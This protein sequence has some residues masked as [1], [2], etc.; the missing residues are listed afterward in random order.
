MAKRTQRQPAARRRAPGPGRGVRA[1]MA[2]GAS[3]A[4]DALRL[5]DR[6]LRERNRAIRRAGPRAAAPAARAVVVARAVRAA[7]APSPLGVLLA[8]GDSWFDYPLNDVLKRLKRE[9]GYDIASVAHM[10]DTIEDMAYNVRQSERFVEALDGLVRAGRIPRGILVSGGGNDIAGREFHMLLDHAASPVP[11]LNTDV[12]RGIVETRVRH[13]CVTLLS[14]ITQLCRQ[15]IGAPVPILLHGYDRAVPDGRGF[16]FGPFPGPWL[17]P[18]FDRKGFSRK[19][20]DATKA[21]VATLIETFNAMLADVAGLPGFE[22]VHYVNL[23]GTLSNGPDYKRWW[24]NELHP[25]ARGFS[26]VAEQFAETLAGI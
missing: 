12:V 26:A 8:E 20:L 3:L 22:H 18:G 10:G 24:A 15:R 2:V 4:D 23:L 21:M 13:A 5:Q 19:D 11:G 25:T 14:A 6:A 9:H 17:R 16:L 1:A 7:G